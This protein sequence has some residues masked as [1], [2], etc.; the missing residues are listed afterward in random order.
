MMNDRE[1][2]EEVIAA[3]AWEPGI[4]AARIGVSVNDGVVTLQGTV[5]TLCQ[6]YIAERTTRD[7]R[8]V[9][10]VA[11]DIEVVPDGTTSRSDPAI[12]SAVANALE[13][14]SALSG[15]N[16]MATVTNGWVTL[17]GIVVA[18]YQRSAAEQAVHNLK[19]VRGISNALLIAH[20]TSTAAGL[21]PLGERP[22]VVPRWGH[23]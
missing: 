5:V 15:A 2:Q 10:A 1:L 7:V 20:S 9:R 14:D 4:D 21:N 3:L 16:V 17:T 19:G 18:E 11:N 6:K 22:F 23:H 13:W 12:A 8:L